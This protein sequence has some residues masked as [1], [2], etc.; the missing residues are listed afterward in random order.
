MV[1]ANMTVEELRK[2]HEYEIETPSPFSLMRDLMGMPELEE[3]G[4][5]GV[6]YGVLGRSVSLYVYPEKSG[7]IRKIEEA[8]RPYIDRYKDKTS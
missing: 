1:F 4:V 2:L 7:N 6:T 3:L 5:A 8:V